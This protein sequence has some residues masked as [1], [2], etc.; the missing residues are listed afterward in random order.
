MATA[1]ASNWLHVD[2]GDESPQVLSTLSS[3]LTL[4][5]VQCDGYVRLL[6]VDISLEEDDE[7]SAKL[8]VF[9]GLKLK[10]E[11]SLPGI[12]TA[13]ESLYV[14]ESEPKTPVIAVAIA[15]SVLFYRHFKPYFKFTIPALDA[16]EL[17]LELWRKLP[18]MKPETHQELL[19]LLKDVDHAKLSRKT[20]RL[21]QLP[22]QERAS[23]ISTHKD[24]PVGR[25]GN[26]VAMCC[27][28]RVSSNVN[29]PSHLVLAVDTG[30]VFVLEPQGFNLIYQAKTCSYEAAVPSLISVHGTYETDFCIVIGTRNGGVYL[31]RK[32]S[33]EGQ[34][35]IKLST[36]LTGLILLPVDQTIVITSMEPRYLCYSKRGKLLYQVQLDA[37]PVCILPLTL[38]HLGITL[39]A[40][41]MQGGRV[42]FFLQRHVVDEFM[43]SQTVA[44]MLYGRM[45]MEDHVLTLITQTGEINF[46]ILR[47]VTH[48]EPDNKVLALTSKGSTKSHPIVDSSILDKSKKSSIFVEQAA[49]EKHQAKSS[50]GSFQVELWRLRHTAARATLDAINSSESTISGD[51]T[52]APVKLSAEVCG[53]GPAFRL[54]LTVQNLSTFKMASNL[55]VLL[56]A[57]RRHYT[58]QQSVARLPSVLPGIPLRVDFE[59]VAVLDA[60]DKLPPA[61]LTPD[62]SQIRVMLLKTGQTKPLIAA[63]VAMPQSEAAF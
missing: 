40:V 43:M 57:D 14:D 32:S 63:V 28:R 36:P 62:N 49:R 27:L 56:H 1:S 3:C 55:V 53:S 51:L 4:S 8:K 37:A 25:I 54:Y 20:Q 9:R 26:I 38:T 2:I 29:P 15:E 6:A 31:L 59:V 24:S 60:V 16:E 58:I 11:Q 44:A 21:L 22:E 47:R 30:R 52:H 48:F 39:V 10:Q 18:V 61:S 17:E 50:Y 12:P 13:I 5:D 46:K 34:E 42:S 19:Q 35:I 41:A 45:G 23:F 7:I 33:S